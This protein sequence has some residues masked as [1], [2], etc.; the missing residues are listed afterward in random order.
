MKHI[1]AR[2]AAKKKRVRRSN[3]KAPGFDE[4]MGQTGRSLVFDI[5]FSETWETSRLSPG[6]VEGHTQFVSMF[7]R[8]GWAT[9]P[10]MRVC[11]CQ[12]GA[13]APARVSARRMIRGRSVEERPFRAALRQQKNWAL[14]PGFHRVAH[15]PSSP[16]SCGSTKEL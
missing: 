16:A 11:P 9:C 14:A 13:G 7:S 15:V 5:A 6:F 10:F 3:A 4:N 12:C 2:E 8:E 1:P